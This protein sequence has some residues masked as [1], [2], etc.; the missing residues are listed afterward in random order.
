MDEP[1]S[2]FLPDK[3]GS[4]AIAVLI[5]HGSMVKVGE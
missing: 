4:G 1:A 3:T 2:S 5:H